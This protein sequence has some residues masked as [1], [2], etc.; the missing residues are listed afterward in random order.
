MTSQDEEKGFNTE[1]SY[2]LIAGV[3]VSVS[4]EIAGLAVYYAQTGS[5][6]F[7]YS[8]QWQLTG[9]NFFSYVGSLFSSLA[10][11]SSI[12][13]MALGII[14]LML[15]PYV[16]VIASAIHFITTKNLKYVAFTFF[17]LTVLTLSLGLR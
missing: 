1:L 8:S 9:P 15:T 2:I 4:L 7:D 17:V 11:A 16:R 14:I 12:Q 10:S 5:L 6:A 3:A 13:L